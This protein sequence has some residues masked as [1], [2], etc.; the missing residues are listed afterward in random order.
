MSRPIAPDGTI[1]ISTP[2]ALA[3]C[4]LATHSP[5]ANAIAAIVRNITESSLMSTHPSL[6]VFAIRPLVNHK[7]PVGSPETTDGGD[8][9]GIAAACR[10]RALVTTQQA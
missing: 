4:G 5:A 1:S 10:L 8:P 2:A 9:L 7:R 3:T 6:F